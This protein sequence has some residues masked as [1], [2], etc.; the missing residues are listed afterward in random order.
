MPIIHEI[1]I[2]VNTYIITNINYQFLIISFRDMLHIIRSKGNWHCS[3][4][5]NRHPGSSPA[6]LT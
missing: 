2:V 4:Q 1:N 3:A 5:Q 6:R